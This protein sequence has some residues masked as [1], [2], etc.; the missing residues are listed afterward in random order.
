MWTQWAANTLAPKMFCF[1]IYGTTG[2]PYS[3]RAFSTSMAVSATCV[4]KGTSNSMANSAA[5][6]KISSVPVY[7]ECGATEGTIKGCPRQRWIYSRA[8]ASD[9]SYDCA[10]GEG[11]FNTVCEQTARIPSSAV[12]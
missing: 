5:S 7:A 2:M 3:A 8:A 11:N 10:S 9:S 4:C 6:L 1:F 12:G